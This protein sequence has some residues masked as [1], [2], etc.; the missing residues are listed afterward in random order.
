M[1]LPM[2]LNAQTATPVPTPDDSSAQPAPA[3]AYTGTLWPLPTVDFFVSKLPTPPKPQSFR[4]RLDM[5]DV[6]A[7]QG[8]MTPAQLEH[9]QWSYTFT[10]FNFSEVLGPKFTAQNYPKTDAFF[11]KVTADANGVIT[12]LKNHYQ[13][14]R[15]FQAY[16]SQIRL[17]V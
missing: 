2:L 1:A 8:Q 6:I 10:V 15:P 5:Q 3:P 16:P 9:A 4:D 14:L 7:R 17:Y 11:K 12:G 13:R